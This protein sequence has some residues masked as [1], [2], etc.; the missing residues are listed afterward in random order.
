[1]TYDEGLAQRVRDTVAT[2][3]GIV[4]RKIFGSLGFFL[5]G[6]MA[7]AA[8]R[9]GLIVRLGPDAERAVEEN[10]VAPFQP[11]DSKPMAGWAIVDLEAVA[12]DEALSEWI[13][14]GVDFA[15]TL[16]PK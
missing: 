10:G 14:A 8:G 1:M 7:V 2:R 15:A 16:P 6:N 13:D 5:H 3:D 12:E 4:E 9:E 11:G